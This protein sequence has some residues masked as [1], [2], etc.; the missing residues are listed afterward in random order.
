MRR[1]VLLQDIVN[2]AFNRIIENQI[3]HNSLYD[4]PRHKYI[5]SNK[6][7]QQLKEI[8]Y[9]SKQY[10]QTT[11]PITLTDFEENEILIELPCKHLFTKES[12]LNWVN[13]EHANC[14]VCKFELD[15]IQQ[16]TPTNRS[17]EWILP[18]TS[19]NHHQQSIRHINYDDYIL[20]RVI[21]N[22]ITDF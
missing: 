1:T 3:M 18:L 21:R 7:K 20:H 22:S 14:P 19:R 9:N 4:E 16:S 13:N 12:I 10:I 17:N 11:C 6:G 8:K 2:N 5:V 15:S